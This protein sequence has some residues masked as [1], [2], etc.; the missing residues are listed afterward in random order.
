MYD[1]IKDNRIKKNILIAVCINS[2]INTGLKLNDIIALLDVKISNSIIKDKNLN[3]LIKFDSN[4]IK[5]KSSILAEYIIH[6]NNLEN[7]SLEVMKN[8]A[9]RANRI[10]YGNEI[11]NVIKDFVSTSNI[12]LVLRKKDEKLSKEIL[13]YYED[14]KD[15]YKRNPF[16]YLQYAMACLD[17][18]YY[19]R[20]G[21]YINIAYKEAQL[22]NDSYSSRHKTKKFDTFQ[23]DTQNGRYMLERAIEEKNEVNAYST[24]SRVHDLFM[25]TLNKEKTQE[26][27][28][29]RQ[30][31]NYKYYFEVYK[32]TLS[33]EERK[34]YIV[35]VEEM[36]DKME[37][38]NVR[39]RSSDINY[40]VSEL[41]GLVSEII[42]SM[43]C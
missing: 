3:E 37:S 34:N 23:I 36:I 32:N 16:F 20:A 11:Q 28:V 27:L 15:S 35:A 17:M 43:I 41:K 42:K 29:Y 19:D 9:I 25:A 26:Q 4:T 7:E 5:A 39:R 22:I 13:Q 1:K 33:Y 31:I 21:E 2:I 18:H 14:L 30:V 8:M 10:K 24:F 38:Y 40:I 12:L 6:K